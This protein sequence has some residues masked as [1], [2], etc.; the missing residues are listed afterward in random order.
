L[1]RHT[2][3]CEIARRRAATSANIDLE[4]RQAQTQSSSAQEK[5]PMSSP[6]ITIGIFAILS[7]MLIAMLVL[8]ENGGNSNIL[9][10]AAMIKLIVSAVPLG[11]LLALRIRL[12]Y[13]RC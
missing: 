13:A 3:R 2:F 8:I 1:Q 7:I 4:R 9:R 6:R 11:L 12:R 10:N 5:H